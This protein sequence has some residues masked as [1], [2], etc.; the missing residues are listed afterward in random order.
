MGEG[1]GRALGLERPGVRQYRVCASGGL[2][3]R[4]RSGRFSSEMQSVGC[5]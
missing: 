1:E 3:F 5:E 4:Q 2:R